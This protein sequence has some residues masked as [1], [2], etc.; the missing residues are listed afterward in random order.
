M[1]ESRAY[2]RVK[3]DHQVSDE[4]PYAELAPVAPPTED[5]C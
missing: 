3:N 2:D 5:P 1:T 4:S